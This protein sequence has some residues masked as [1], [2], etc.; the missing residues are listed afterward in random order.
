[1]PAAWHRG[2]FKDARLLEL[3]VPPDTPL[4]REAESHARELCDPALFNHC[5]RTWAFS[6]MFAAR[7]RVD[8]DQELLFVACL[9][10]DLGL[11]GA[12]DGHDPTAACFAVEGARAAHSFVCSQGDS[13]QRARV[14]AEAIS[15]HLNVNVH[16][17]FGPV[18]GLLSKGV[19]LDVV[20]RRMERIAPESISAVVGTWPR[21]GS[22]E[23]LVEGTERQ[24]K[25]RPASRS[26]LLHQLGFT[27]LVLS[28]PIDQIRD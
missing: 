3:P 1:L 7:D 23:F 10:H 25:L 18:A 17:D 16:D 12:H 13:E 21:K 4:A 8:H 28:N 6:A 15:L 19:T 22:G 9:L 2:A 27:K 5:F 11:T 24:A 20:G 14:V 26:A